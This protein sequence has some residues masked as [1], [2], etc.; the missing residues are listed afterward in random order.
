MSRT[1]TSGKGWRLLTN[2]PIPLHIRLEVKSA[3]CCSRYCCSKGGTH[4]WLADVTCAAS[5][6]SS[7]SYILYV[8]YFMK[9][10][11]GSYLIDVF[12]NWFE[13]AEQCIVWALQEARQQKHTSWLACVTIMPKDIQLDGRIPKGRAWTISLMLYFNF[14]LILLLFCPADA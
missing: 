13:F 14:K 12:A 6:E 1:L 3:I 11:F 8:S 2:R 9:K 4:G 7:L 5:F 10:S